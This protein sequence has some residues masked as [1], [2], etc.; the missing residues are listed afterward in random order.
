M[1]TRFH[2]IPSNL[3]VKIGSFATQR[4]VMR[5][6]YVKLEKTNWQI[7]GKFVETS[8]LHQAHID[9]NALP[10][11]A[12]GQEICTHARALAILGELIMRKATFSVMAG[13]VS[14][15]ALM[16]GLSNAAMAESVQQ[17]FANG[18]DAV[19][20]QGTFPTGDI[21]SV[22]GPV[23]PSPLGFGTAGKFA[24][25]AGAP[26]AQKT[27]E[28]AFMVL[29][30]NGK[31]ILASVG[32][33]GADGTVHGTYANESAYATYLATAGNGP[34]T[35]G[36]I[37][38]I[39]GGASFAN[40]TGAHTC[41]TGNLQK[42]TDA[43]NNIKW[44]AV[45]YAHETNYVASATLAASSTV[46]TTNTIGSSGSGKVLVTSAGL[47]A[48]SAA[49][50]SA[51][52]KCSY[53]SSTTVDTKAT[54]A[55][56]PAA[57]Y[58]ITR[59]AAA[60]VIGNSQTIAG[61]GSLVQ[62]NTDP[63]GKV[64]DRTGV[65]PTG[66]TVTDKDGN[67]TAVTAGKTVL[68]APGKGSIT[69][70][71][72]ADPVLTVTDSTFH[73]TTTIHNGDVA[74]GNSLTVY[75]HGSDAFNV[76]NGV[77]NLYGGA[78]VSGGTNASGKAS[79]LT[80][81]SASLTVDGGT[82]VNGGVNINSGGLDVKGGTTTDSLKVTGQS[83]FGNAGQ[84]TIGA[85]GDVTTSGNV[86]AVNGG[87]SATLS[88]A[89]ITVTDGTSTSSVTS[90]EVKSKK[91]VVGSG[92][93][94]TTIDGGTVTGVTGSFTT[95]T[96]KDSAGTSYANVGNELTSLNT[97]VASNSAAIA[98]LKSD[99]STLYKLNAMA[100]AMP[101]AYLNPNERFSLAGGAG[102]NSDETGFG[103]AGA[104]RFDKNWSGYGGVAFSGGE[105][106]GKVG[107]R[108]GW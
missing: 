23:D 40:T 52:A 72:T 43:D 50:C 94:S 103:L 95:L 64:T 22:T 37:C 46:P 31:A 78:Y 92:T 13:T 7:S 47:L 56:V 14:A 41:G 11:G 83:T 69:L 77:S 12:R 85:N 61:P 36:E 6:L 26:G 81:N 38:V 8:C 75:G 5:C 42:P 80:A 57:D 65:G 9:E 45:D 28:G 93:N 48:I 107:A 90:T 70:D 101:D 1:H 3:T 18:E 34:D 59:V 68:N 51:T 39:G 49:D 86:K 74:V 66:V 10:D 106:V 73:G 82:F 60:A 100:V 58:R 44:K 32:I 20:V 33:V 24:P 88:S 62:Q 91:V 2:L 108:V 19:Y 63:T 98:G 76:V 99:V 71:A 16:V 67:S 84:T 96:T 102:F 29:D 97:R 27:T 105:A 53:E 30:S 89:G 79:D 25:Y 35:N 17:P 4:R 21:P 55:V 87:N 104:V 15:L 54:A